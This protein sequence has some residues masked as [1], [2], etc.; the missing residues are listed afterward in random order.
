MLREES[1]ATLFWDAKGILLTGYLENSRPVK[2]EYY[3]N[4]LRKLRRAIVEQRR[5]LVTRGVLLLHDNA[6][7][8]RSHVAQAAIRECGF[9]QLDHPP[10]SPDLASSDSLQT[11]AEEWLGNQERSFFLLRQQ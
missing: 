3:A 7:V 8:H 4:V 6:P 9:E 1:E 11:A 5:G 2:G 10:Y